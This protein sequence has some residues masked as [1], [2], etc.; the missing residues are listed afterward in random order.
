MSTNQISSSINK[1]RD[2]P[3]KV[4]TYIISIT[5]AVIVLLPFVEFIK[6]SYTGTLE[7]TKTKDVFVIL[8]RYWKEFKKFCA[9]SNITG[10]KNSLY[11]SLASTFC[12][13]YFSA[14]TAYAI[15]AYEWKLKEI[16]SKFIT[17]VMMIPSTISM[18]GFYQLVWK[19]HLI[20]RLYMLILPTIAA[21]IT[22]YFMRMYLQATFSKDLVESARIDGAGE[23][24]IFNQMIL[25][26]LKPAIATQAIFCFLTSWND[27]FTP[28]IILISDA[29]KTLPITM[30][31]VQS[32]LFMETGVPLFDT[33]VSILPPLILFAILSRHLVEGVALGSVKY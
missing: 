30:T 19:F 17:F 12:S 26:L 2:L 24:M 14:L 32:F 13:I 18:I 31:S 11:V 9:S 7:A 15:T 10:L 8:A 20:N 5:V 29:K 16:F 1:R 33:L 21:P 28:S 6:E 25:P 23:F 27:V 22:V 3:L 4:I